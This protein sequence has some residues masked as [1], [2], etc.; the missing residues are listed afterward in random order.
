MFGNV[1]AAF[2]STYAQTPNGS[3]Y[4]G[5]WTIASTPTTTS[6]TFALTAGNTTSGA[7]G[8]TNWAWTEGATMREVNSSQP[9][10][11]IW[12]LEAVANLP[13]ISACG[14]ASK[15]DVV[16][17][18]GDGTLTIRLDK[19]APTSI[20]AV[21][22]IF[23]GRPPVLASLASTWAPFPDRFRFV[24]DQAFLARAYRYMSSPKTPSEYA[25]SEQFIQKAL[26]GNDVE[27]SDRRIYPERALMAMDGLYDEL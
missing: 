1:D 9:V 24:I 10:P 25:V 17:D 19:V 4:S 3:G 7:P 22:L 6:F 12:S 15:V 16:A 21:G 18:N 27:A 20:F 11:R 23:Q 2:N 5:G 13:L 14:Q 8:I 26:Q